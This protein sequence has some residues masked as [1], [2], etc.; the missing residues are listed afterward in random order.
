AL[1]LRR[2]RGPRRTRRPAP[3]LPRCA[4]AAAAVGSRPGGAPAGVA[5]AHGP[6]VGGPE[7]ARGGRAERAVRRLPRAAGRRRRARG[8]VPGLRRGR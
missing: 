3:F 5:H 7:S 2:R 4:A 8:G 6:R 1:R